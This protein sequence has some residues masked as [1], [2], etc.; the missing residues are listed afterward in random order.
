M[1][2]LLYILLYHCVFAGGWGAIVCKEGVCLPKLTIYT[3]SKPGKWSRSQ[4]PNVI[5]TGTPTPLGGAIEYVPPSSC[6]TTVHIC[7]R[8]HH[9]PP[10]PP[11]L[12]HAQTHCGDD[13]DPQCYNAITWSSAIIRQSHSLFCPPAIIWQSDSL[14]CLSVWL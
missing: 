12:S 1:C 8:H 13:S 4:N 7:L 3:L 2:I 5:I 11:T 6:H 9:V 14:V 10:L